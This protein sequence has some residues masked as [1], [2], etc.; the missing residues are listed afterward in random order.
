MFA[1]SPS[2]GS[3]PRDAFAPRHA[4]P[5]RAAVDRAEEIFVVAGDEADVRV[6]E[7]DALERFVEEHRQL[8][9]VSGVAAVVGADQRALPAGD[10]DVARALHEHGVDIGDRWIGGNA[11]PGLRFGCDAREREAA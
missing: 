6:A 1:W 8:D 7:V 4:V 3:L 5:R 9:V 11:P 2:A 10:E